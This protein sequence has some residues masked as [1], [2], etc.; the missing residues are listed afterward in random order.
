[1]NIVTSTFNQNDGGSDVGLTRYNRAPAH[2]PAAT[3]H[4][5]SIH[6]LGHIER[7]IQTAAARS[8]PTKVDP[9]SSRPADLALVPSA[10]R[11]I[12]AV[13]RMIER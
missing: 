7:P 1:M 9:T 4:N 6:R 11:A 8:A 3:T 5:T 12:V 2:N 10:C 13:F